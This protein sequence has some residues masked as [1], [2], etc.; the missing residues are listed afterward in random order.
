[1]PDLPDS[2]DFEIVVP[3]DNNEEN[4]TK[5]L[6]SGN[7][8]GMNISIII[9]NSCSI[10]QLILHYPSF[11]NFSALFFHPSDHFLLFLYLDL[12][13]QSKP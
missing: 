9:L 2:A 7:A 13:Y 1:M 3:Q 6:G 5:D 4:L 12:V 10:L 8:L 11:Y